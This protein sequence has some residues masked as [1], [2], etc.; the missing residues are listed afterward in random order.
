MVVVDSPFRSPVSLSVGS[1]AVA[2]MPMAP[3]N[4][5]SR[6]H[7]TVCVDA[8]CT[9]FQVLRHVVG[10]DALQAAPLVMSRICM[11]FRAP[12]SQAL[13]VALHA[14]N[15]AGAAAPDPASN[16]TAT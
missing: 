1:G 14:K 2:R 6:A 3:Q 16:V 11:R 7:G 9:H 4:A 5:A 8:I 13:D 10:P 15:F 12:P